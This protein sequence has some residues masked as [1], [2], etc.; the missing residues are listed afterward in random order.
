VFF[1]F[2]LE[3]WSD[4]TLLFRVQAMMQMQ[5]AMQTL[6][7][8]GMMPATGGLGGPMAMP[9]MGFPGMANPYGGLDF[10]SLMGGSGGI[11]APTPVRPASEEPAVRYASQLQ[12]LQAMGFSDDAASLRALVATGGNINAAVERLLGSM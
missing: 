2:I 3:E 9:G 1:I 12:Q 10:S 5:Q 11:P 7:S 6:Q 4:L 8:N